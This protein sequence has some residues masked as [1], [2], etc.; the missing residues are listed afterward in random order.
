M[1]LK[2][3]EENIWQIP[4]TGEMLVPTIIYASEK[5]LNLMKLDKTLVQAQNVACLPGIVKASY[6]MPDAHEGYG[7]CIGGVGAFDIDKGIIS[8]GGVGYDINCGVRMLKTNLT[9]ED[10]IKNKDALINLIFKNVPAGLGSKAT[11]RFDRKTLDE[12]LEKG[13]EWTVKEGYGWK[14]DLER[15]EENGK[16]RVS[17]NEVSEEAIKRGMPQI[18][19]LGAGNHFL[20]VQAVEKIFNEEIAKVFGIEREGQITVMIHCGS[21]GLGHQVASDYLRLMEKNFGINKLPDR[22][23]I[24]AP[25]Q[26]EM[27]QK[28]FSAMSASANYAWANR[29]M[30]MHWVRESFSSIF[31]RSAESMD[32]QLIYDV[33]HNIAKVEEHVVDGKKR[34]LVV[35]RKGATRSFGPGREEL[36]G[37]YK[38]V[39]QPVLIPGSMGTASYLLV[40]TDKAEEI[41]F[42]STAH[43][44]GRVMSRHTAMK[45]FTGESIKRALE[46]K[47][48]TLRTTSWRGI[49]EEAPEV[50]KD[51]DEVVKV[52]HGVGIGN[53]VAKVRPLEVLKG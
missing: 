6:A 41:S 40:G 42:G 7:F 17:S 47:G 39:G 21:R 46:S 22:E 5:L 31:K 44:A 23:L 53:L 50:Y 35:H 37:I 8:P 33:A 2:K 10:V 19:S 45:K 27:G 26:S 4:K 15:T 32:M 38:K 1:E 36:P 18:G 25:F 12:V 49:V 30:I 52:S 24:N 9:K 48:I 13:A 16:M 51:V 34:K 29:Q 3:I 11:L 28:Y 20:E 14:Q 43:G